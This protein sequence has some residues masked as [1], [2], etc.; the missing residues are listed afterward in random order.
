[1]EERIRL[2]QAALKAGLFKSRTAA[3]EAI[4]KELVTVNGVVRNKPSFSVTEEDEI[5]YLGEAPVY[6]GR[7]GYKLEKALKTFAIDVNGAVCLDAGAS[8][9]GFTDCLLQRG[10]EIVY[11][12]EG[13]RDQLDEKLRK[14]ARVRS[15]EKTD[16][17]AMPPEISGQK[18]DILV[19][20]LS[21]ISLKLVMPHL[22]PL[23][24]KGANAV[25]LVKPQFE[26]GREALGKN[27]IVK[28]PRDHT[29]CL[30][31]VMT[32]S[33]SLGW[34][35]AGLTYS[36]ICGGSGNIEYLLLLRNDASDIYPDADGVV[37]SAFDALK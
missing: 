2:D 36:P 33:R 16:V 8:T 17:R 15:F 22:L 12:V 10:A 28:S 1:M 23:L 18:F 9:G 3:R 14:D 13:G 4:E 30:N 27:G 5:K 35:V 31:D 37:K 21:F 20:D 24:K 26:C 32:A 11:A 19:C 7:G 29:R 6:V 25:F 34:A